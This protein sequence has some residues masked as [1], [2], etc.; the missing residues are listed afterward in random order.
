M[1][2]SDL[3]LRL[4][5]FDGDSDTLLEVVSE[6][7]LAQID[8]QAARLIQRHDVCQV[9]YAGDKLVIFFEDTD[10]VLLVKL[11]QLEPGMLCF[12]EAEVDSIFGISKAIDIRVD[13]PFLYFVQIQRNGVEDYFLRDPTQTN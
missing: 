5:G 12:D 10:Q 2:T 8:A 6:L 1:L 13:G 7:S 11:L 3:S 9:Q 4:L